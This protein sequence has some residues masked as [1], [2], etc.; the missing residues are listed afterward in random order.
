[1]PM[2]HCDRHVNSQI[3]QF[4]ENIGGHKDF[5]IPENF[6]K[7]LEELKGSYSSPSGYPAAC[8]YLR[9]VLNTAITQFSSAVR[10]LEIAA[11]ERDSLK[12]ALELVTD[13]KNVDSWDF[14]STVMNMVLDVAEMIDRAKDDGYS[15]LELKAHFQKGEENE[16]ELPISDAEFEIGELAMDTK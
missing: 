13:Q 14:K 7:L 9:S 16:N 8:G 4:K 15:D 3:K 10:Q 2:P 5:L 6:A 12:W 1:M 11:S